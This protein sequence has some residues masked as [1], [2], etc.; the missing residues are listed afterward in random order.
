M[1]RGTSPDLYIKVLVKIFVKLPIG[2]PLMMC[3]LLVYALI[4]SPNATRLKM[5][6]FLPPLISTPML[7]A[8]GARLSWYTALRLAR[9]REVS[10]S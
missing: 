6:L 7:A 9:V 1:R 10:T 3:Y 2:P 8:D 5:V 4:V